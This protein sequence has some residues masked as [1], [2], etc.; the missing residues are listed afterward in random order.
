VSDHDD[1]TLINMKVTYT[2]GDLVKLEFFQDN[3]RVLW[4]DLTRAQAADWGA[5]IT[6]AAETWFRP[7]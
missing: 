5:K 6:S 4:V 7:N 2:D 3:K 1:P